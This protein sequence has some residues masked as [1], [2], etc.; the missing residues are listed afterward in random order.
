MGYVFLEFLCDN[1]PQVVEADL[2]L[3]RCAQ[4][5]MLSADKLVEQ[6]GPTFDSR[7]IWNTETEE[8]VAVYRPVK[9]LIPLL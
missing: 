4:C 5:L 6:H 3:A 2:A 8:I 9:S 1:A 7:S